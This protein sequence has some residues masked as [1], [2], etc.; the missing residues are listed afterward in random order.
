MNQLEEITSKHCDNP[1]ANYNDLK[2]LFFNCILNRSPV[3][4]HTEGLIKIAPKIFESNGASTKIIRP[5]DYDIP[6]G[7][8]L[9]MSQTSEWDKDEWPEIQK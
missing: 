4:F 2:V 1:P 6:A 9:D 8:G 3:L 7:L 5:V